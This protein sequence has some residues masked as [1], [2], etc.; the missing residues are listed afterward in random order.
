MQNSEADG[1]TV[2]RNH[3]VNDGFLLKQ[4]TVSTL[5]TDLPSAVL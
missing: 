4:T 1:G 2:K 5:I 3:S